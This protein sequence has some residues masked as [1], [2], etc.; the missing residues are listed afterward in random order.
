MR[1]SCRGH[2]R[3]DQGLR[4]V[5]L[6]HSRAQYSTWLFG[7]GIRIQ[8]TTPATRRA[9][10]GLKVTTYY[11][12]RPA[13]LRRPIIVFREDCRQ[14]GHYA[15]FGVASGWAVIFPQLAKT[16]RMTRQSVSRS[17]GRFGCARTPDERDVGGRVVS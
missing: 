8:P 10:H 2:L 1:R 16:S 7:G 14:P 17:H 11:T 5:G 3:R 12:R 6:R 13:T 15:G 9:S 4:S